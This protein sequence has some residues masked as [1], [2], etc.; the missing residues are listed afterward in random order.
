MP[1]SWSTPSPIRGRTCLRRSALYGT[2]SRPCSRAFKAQSRFSQ[3]DLTL[4]EAQDVY[5]RFMIAPSRS[6]TKGSAAMA[7]AGLRSFLGFFCEDYRLHDYM[8]GRENCQRFFRDWFEGSVNSD[9]ARSSS[10]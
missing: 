9:G 10:E 1:S 4:A 8:L 5:S 6:G 7:S 2:R 3:I